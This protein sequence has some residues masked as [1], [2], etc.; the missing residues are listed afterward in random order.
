MS[1]NVDQHVTQILERFVSEYPLAHAQLHV[2]SPAWRWE[3]SEFLSREVIATQIKACQE[4]FG[5]TQSKQ[6][7]MLWIHICCGNI[8]APLVQCAVFSQDYLNADLPGD[9]CRVFRQSASECFLGIEPQS[10]VE[11]AQT[12]M[13][14]LA[15]SI[16]ALISVVADITEL[17]AAPLWA[18]AADAVVAPILGAGVQEIECD[19]AVH[20]AD[21]FLRELAAVAPVRL[22]QLEVFAYE[23]GSLESYCVLGTAS[24]VDADSDPE[25]VAGLRA[26]CCQIYHSPQAELCSSCPK[27]PL[28]ERL[29]AIA[30]YAASLGV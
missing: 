23:D 12:Q 6:A 9:G 18:I 26:S 1:A 20:L 28:E 17:R 2:Q 13:S 27:H 30:R 25:F 16:A 4:Y 29:G 22:P 19:N 5:V 8:F 10:L 14:Q 21:L 24:A 7:G 3:G 11:D 15:G